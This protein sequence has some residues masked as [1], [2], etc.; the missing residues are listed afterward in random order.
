MHNII[1]VGLIQTAQKYLLLKQA[2]GY[3]LW[4]LP[5]G[6]L[7]SGENLVDAITRETFEETGLEIKVKA[8]VAVRN[9]P[10]QTVFIFDLDATGGSLA[11]SVPN[12][13]E[14]TAWVAAEDLDRLADQIEQLP[15]FILKQAF[16]GKLRPLSRQS[17]A[18]YTGN[19]D[20]FF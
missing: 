10:E 14:A 9:K 16:T 20:L 11:E 2:Y 8:L 13:I 15:F 1:V 12:E 18:G 6:I 3:H 19:A 4:T 5:G 7:E 17:W